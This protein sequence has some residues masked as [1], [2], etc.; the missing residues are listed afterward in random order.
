MIPKRAHF[1]DSTLM[2]YF[3]FF[4]IF[5]I[6]FYTKLIDFDVALSKLSRGVKMFRLTAKLKTF[7]AC[8]F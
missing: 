2:L 4:L 6:N 8:N 3:E 1:R 7:L 5:L